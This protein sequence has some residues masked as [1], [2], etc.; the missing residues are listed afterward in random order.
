[1]S[2][3][4]SD[5]VDSCN[6]TFGV[7]VTYNFRDSST[8]VPSADWGEEEPELEETEQ[9]R[10]MVRRATVV[11]DTDDV[12]SPDRRGSV[13]YSGET[14]SIL[15]VQ[16][17]GNSAYALSLVRYEQIETAPSYRRT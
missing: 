5:L 10:R 15:R 12:A 8:S 7:A 14:W 17:T 4:T 16:P 9:G 11:I 13:T 3:D 6:A 2:F 1:M